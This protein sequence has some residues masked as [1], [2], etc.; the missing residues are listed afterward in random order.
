MSTT[1]RK[2]NVYS[3]LF[4]GQAEYEAIVS[5]HHNHKLSTPLELEEC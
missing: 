4:T 3:L 1:V 2:F 5:C